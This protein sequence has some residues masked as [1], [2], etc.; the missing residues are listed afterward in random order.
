MNIESVLTFCTVFNWFQYLFFRRNAGW[1]AFCNIIAW[2][3]CMVC[4]LGGA[5]LVLSYGLTF[6]NDKT[7]QWMTSMIVSFFAS[8][9]LT[10][11]IKV[12]F[13]KKNLFDGNYYFFFFQ[14]LLVI[15][16]MSHC[17][18]KD[19]YGDDHV[20]QDEQLPKVYYKEDDPEI[21]K[22]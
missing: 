9:L 11:P 16:V 2:I 3:L 20:F 21:G 12:F 14:I 10:Q 4:I 8:L 7:Y 1:P 5:F 15:W 13:S 17:I 19:S 18:K 22:L 6:G